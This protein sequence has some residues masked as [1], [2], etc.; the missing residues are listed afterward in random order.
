MSELKC[1][2]E[3]A[4]FGANQAVEPLL[5]NPL[6]AKDVWDIVEDLGLEVPRHSSLHFLNFEPLHQEWLKLLTKFFIITKHKSLQ[7][8]TLVAYLSTIRK[9]SIFLSSSVYS[10]D[11]IGQQT[12]EDFDYYLRSENPKISSGTI[13]Q[14]YT[15]LTVF[16]NTCRIEGWLNVNTHWFK[17]R[18]VISKPKF[19]EI[20]YIPEEVWN[21]LQENLY[22]LP[23]QIQRMVLIIRAT[24]LRIGELHITSIKR[25]F[26]RRSYSK[27]V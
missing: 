3:C 25:L 12:F 1:F 15:R 2:Y 6:I 11:N 27:M 20:D 21:Q 23:E 26:L 18:H 10:F 8:S 13:S 5:Q 17:A 24:G 4:N 14:K 19:D 22:L 16:F 9:F 7:S